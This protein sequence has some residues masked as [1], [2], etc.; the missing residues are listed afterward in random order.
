MGKD[1]ST[2]GQ[3]M[4]GD[5][6]LPLGMRM[7]LAF[8][9]LWLATC[10]LTEIDGHHW[11]QLVEARRPL[12]LALWHHSLIYALYRFRRVRCAIMVSASRDGELV[13]GALKRWGQIP[14]RGSSN[15][16]GVR[17][18]RQMAR[19]MCQGG[20]PGGIVA[21]GSQGP[22]FKAQPGALF[23]AREARCPIVPMGMH[24]HPCYRFRS[25]DRTMLP[26]PF[27][28]VWMAYGEPMVVEGELRGKG[29][30]IALQRLENGLNSARRAAMEAAGQGG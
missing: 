7:G 24:V 6:R 4:E 15:R 11:M 27:S 10:R 23:L 22:A 13:A 17:A 21:D 3:G 1:F 19:L 18:L 29:L 12:V 8:M 25:W 2:F 28:R 5:S 14:V 30:E 20:L 26:L 16:H 9:D